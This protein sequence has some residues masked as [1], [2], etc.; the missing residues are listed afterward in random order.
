[1]LLFHGASGVG[2]TM[3]ANAVA[4]HV[5]R[6]VLLI[7]FPSLGSNEAGQAIRFIFRCPSASL[8]CDMLI[9]C[10]LDRIKSCFCWYSDHQ[11]STSFREVLYTVLLVLREDTQ[12]QYSL[13]RVSPCL[14]F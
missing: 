7:N 10:G 13:C 14:R 1:V 12:I 8:S 6:K 5:H 11:I 4:K 9:Q 2:K 3:M